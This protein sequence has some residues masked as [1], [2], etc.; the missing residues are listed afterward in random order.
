MG[1]S[2]AKNLE[3][4]MGEEDLHNIPFLNAVQVAK[5]ADCTTNNV[6]YWAKYGYIKSYPPKEGAKYKRFTIS[7]ALELKKMMA[8][9]K[10]GYTIA[11]AVL[12]V[13]KLN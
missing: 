7:D 1:L 4:N 9:R 8:L 11:Q 6:S 13:K 5:I 2:A 3:K 10:K 12:K